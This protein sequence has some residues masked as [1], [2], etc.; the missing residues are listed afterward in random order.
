[1]RITKTLLLVLFVLSLSAGLALADDPVVLKF[2]TIEPPQSDNN[3][4]VWTPLFDK[5]NKEGEGIL[6]IE[7]FAGGTLGR[8]PMQQ[9]KILMDGVT[10]MVQIINA[11]HPGQLVDDPIIMTPFTANNCF[12][13]SM[14]FHYMQEKQMLRGYDDLVVLGQVCLGIYGIHSNYPIKVPADL[15]GKKLRTAGKL[16]HAL[17]E[18]LGAT[19]VAMPVTKVAESISRGVVDGT[20]QDWTGMAVFRINDVAK[21]HVLI[22]FGTNPL[23]VAM[24]KKKYNSLPPEARAII[25][26]Y[27]GGYFTRFWA[28]RLYER[29]NEIQNQ[30]SKD[31]KH[32]LYTPNAAELKQWKA[33]TEPVIASWNKVN[34]RWDELLKA[35]E[36]GLVK[37]RTEKP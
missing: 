14:S 18:N 17:A 1:M 7:T 13:C 2:A 30:I 20:L 27:K 31:P 11:Y 29:V 36:A 37:A 32:T 3:K 35:Y 12:E 5:M 6:K 16:F 34:D 28:K 15:K 21:Y 9:I 26:K 4:N 8:N 19:P 10:D 24:T 33:A 22:P 23:T 25:D